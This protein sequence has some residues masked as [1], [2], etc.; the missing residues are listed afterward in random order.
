MT[1]IDLAEFVGH[2]N[3]KGVEFW[4]EAGQLR[5]RA[6]K[7]V[8]TPSV[9]DSLVAHKEELLRMLQQPKAVTELATLPTI[10]P[11]PGQRHAPFPLTD[12]QQAY[13]AGESGYFELGN[14]AA[15]TYLAFEVDNLDDGRFIQALRRM[16]ARHD[17][18]RAVALPEGQQVILAEVPTL[19]VSVVDLRSGAEIAPELGI[20]AVRSRMKRHGPTTGSWPLIEVL[21]HRLDDR[22][23]LVHL[24]MSLLVCDAWSSAIFL[25]ECMAFYNGQEASLAPLTLSFRDYVLG[26]REVEQTEQYRQAQEY[27]WRRVPSMPPAPDLPLAVSPSA[28]EAPNFI[29]HRLRLNPQTWA[30]LKQLAAQNGVTA[31]TFVLAAYAA[32]LAAWSKNSHFTLNVLFFNRLP[33]H[34]QVYDLIG[35]FSATVLVEIPEAA[36]QPFAAWARAIQKQ[37]WSDLEHSLVSGVRV[38]GEMNRVHGGTSRAAMPVTFASLLNLG[39]QDAQD[40]EVPWLSNIVQS[41]LQTPQVWLDHQVYEEGGTLIS[42]WDVVEHLFPEGMVEAM[43]A[44]FERL[45]TQITTAPDMWQ[46]PLPTLVPA[47]QLARRAAVNATEAPVSDDLLHSAIAAQAA[48]R[49]DQLAVLAPARSLS[50]AELQQRALALAHQLRQRGAAPNTLVAV[51]LPKGW[52]QVVA[53]LAVLHSG[54]AYLPI[55]PALPASRLHYILDHAEVSIVLTQEALRTTVAWPEEVQLVAVDTDTTW[56]RQ[57]WAPQAPVQGPDDLAYVI[58][59]SGSTGLPKGVMITHRAAL[60]TIIDI[61]ERFGVT[62]KDRALALSS[63]SFDLSVYDIFG[64]LAAGGAVVMPDPVAARDPAHWAD[65]A[66]EHR[67]TIWNSVPALL[68]LLV[69]YL[70]TRPEAAPTSL[71]AALL[72]GDWISLRLPEQ[73]ALVL[74]QLALHSLG[75]ATEAA[76]WSITYPIT[77]VQPH[78]ASIPY[79]APLRNQQFHVLNA[80]MQPCP[81]WVPGQLYI[82]G[83][84]LALGYWHDDAKTAAQFVI[85]PVTGERLYKTGDLGRY[86]PDGTIEFLG[87]EDFQVKIQGY[88]VELGEIEA[89]LQHPSVAAVVVNAVGARQ[90]EKRLVGYIVPAPGH[91]VDLAA[92]REQAQA[93]LPTYMVPV[94][95]I[96]LDSLPLT[97]NGKVDRKALPSPEDVRPQTGGGSVASRDAL[98][99]ALTQIWEELLNVRPIGVTDNFFDLGGHSLLAVRLMTQI[100]QHL[101]QRL[102]IGALLEAPTI[103]HLAAVLRARR[104]G[105]AAWSPLVGIQTHGERTPFF[106]VH[107]AG[108]NVLCYVELARQLGPSQPFY[109]LQAAGMERGQAPLQSI[110]AT[111]SAYIAALRAVQPEGPYVLGGWSSGGVVA[112]EMAQQLLAQG[113]QI[114]KLV[115]I[116][117]PAPGADEPT[118]ELTLLTW[119]IN[120]LGGRFATDLSIS[121]SEL[122]ELNPSEQMVYVLE[123]ARKAQIVFPDTDLDQ[124]HRFYDVFRGTMRACERY[125]PQ[126]YR[127]QVTLIRAGGAPIEEF[128]RNP[129]YHQP[130]FGWDA[131]LE[132]SVVVDYSLPGDHYTIMLQPLVQKLARQLSEDFASVPAANQTAK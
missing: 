78:W 104:A 6:P 3:Q 65:L 75:G 93:K 40:G 77:Q 112:Y 60:N 79:G 13:W 15:H 115:L 30:A 26:L 57:C 49:P 99:L 22:R 88:R 64:L 31:S 119:F 106:C 124:L 35:N 29:R 108:G 19:D 21:I 110:E 66:R 71:R 80:Q 90:G 129:A 72:S 47:E 25:R 20:E 111:A 83:V 87:R 126:P 10:E 102:Q 85:H 98:E 122:R 9:R 123:H 8:I 117:S 130:L 42:N 37:L 84:G 76:I 1:T 61:N 14:I 7:G 32:T 131:L 105:S 73:A 56:E 70:A 59:T 94:A 69:E 34:P 48:R 82:G 109:G 67:V 12:I 128:A 107:P 81:V 96:P 43:V 120:D 46:E 114:A 17:M 121:V 45:L 89:A 86:L 41:S 28:I 101:G 4:V 16:V 116:D 54:A 92:L 97:P 103:E 23:S 38:L 18:L 53:T 33:L 113:Q 100:D 118:D 58:Y 127:G 95:L 2:L 11:D 24:N 39:P 132:G 91:S 68:Q 55:D 36:D 62:Y 5:Y 63:L 125:T 74:P 27:W 51:A 50:Y 44:S 52:E